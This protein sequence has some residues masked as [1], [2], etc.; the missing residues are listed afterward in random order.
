MKRKLGQVLFLMFA[1]LCLSASTFALDLDTAKVSGYVGEMPNGYL[2]S[3]SSTPSAE[4]ASLI[5]EINQ[6][7][8]AKYRQIAKQNGTDLNVVEA[9]AGKKAIN[10]TSSGQYVQ[11][12]SGEWLKK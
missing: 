10:M 5:S 3:P 12:P 1:V 4:V 9:L 6:K 8:K 2:G 7:R 11:L